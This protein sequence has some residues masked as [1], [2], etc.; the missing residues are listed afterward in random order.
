MPGMS[1][2]ELAA[3]ASRRGIPAILMT[4]EE[5]ASRELA[6]NGWRHLHKPFRVDA[7]LAEVRDTLSQAAQ[8]L[9]MVRDSLQRLR[10]TADEH[11]QA[12]HRLRQTLLRSQT[13]SKMC[14]DKEDPT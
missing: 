9:A 2:V 7:L 6:A 4:G 14:R 13:A 1:G 12:F 10:Q 11:H 3:E 5:E 8:N